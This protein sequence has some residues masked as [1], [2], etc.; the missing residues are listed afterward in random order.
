MYF[1]IE[2]DEL[3]KKYNDICDKVSNSMKKEL[4]C[5][6]IYNKIILET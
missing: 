2:D 6:P 5:K 3:M 4:D 1:S